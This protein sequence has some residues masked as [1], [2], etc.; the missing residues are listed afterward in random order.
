MNRLQNR[1]VIRCSYGGC[2][3]RFDSLCA[4]PREKPSRF[5]F[6]WTALR[7]QR[8]GSLASKTS[9]CVH[10]ALWHWSALRKASFLNLAALTFRLRLLN[11]DFGYLWSLW[12][13]S[14]YNMRAP[15]RDHSWKR[16]AWALR[17]YMS[18]DKRVTHN[19]FQE[20]KE[21]VDWVEIHGAAAVTRK[22]MWF[23]KEGCK[24]HGLRTA[25]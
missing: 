19:D 8:A 1:F 25:L 18:Q 23:V 14:I 3:Y 10:G 21:K 24:R 12:Q 15:N 20:L 4:R 9:L 2:P 13:G 16:K 11:K 17:M 22:T 7:T 5:N 6:W